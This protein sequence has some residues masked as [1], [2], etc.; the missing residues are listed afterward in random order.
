M[1]RQGCFQQL[2]FGHDG[3][4]LEH[5]RR[6]VVNRFRFVVSRA[7]FMVFGRCLSHGTQD[8]EFIGGQLRQLPLADFGGGNAFEFF[9]A[10]AVDGVSHFVV[11]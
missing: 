9:G 6:G 7:L 8:D 3:F 1:M 10:A 2:M 4:P 11:R 5:M